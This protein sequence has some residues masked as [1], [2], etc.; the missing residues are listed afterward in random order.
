MS[1]RSSEALLGYAAGGNGLVACLALE[2]VVRRVES[3]GAAVP[4]LVDRLLGIVSQRIGWIGWFTLRALARAAEEPVIHRVLPRLGPEWRDPFLLGALRDFVARRKA[5]GEPLGLA[6]RL[7]NVT[8]EAMENLRHL[9]TGLRDVAPELEEELARWESEHVDT[10]FLASVGRVWPAPEVVEG[11][12]EEAELEAPLPDRIVSHPALVD[13][14]GEILRVLTGESPRPILVVGDAGVGKSVLIRCAAARL[15]S[16]GWVVFEASAADVM[17]GQSFIGQ[18]E[19]RIQKLLRQIGGK[20]VLWIAPG[21]NELAWAGRHSQSTTGVLDM[22]L[23]HLEAGSI[24]LLGELRSQALEKLVQEQPRIR[25]VVETLRLPPMGSPQTL[26]LAR[27]WSEAHGP[28]AEPLLSEETLREAY[29]L[30]SQYL[31]DRAPP[32][33]LLHFLTTIRN[34]LRAS[35]EERTITT[36]DL[37]VTLSR[38]TGLPLGIL[39]ERRGLDLGKLQRFFEARVMGQ[40]EAVEC[41]VERVAMIKAGLTDPT[42]PQGVFLFVG[43][44]GTG[45]TEIAKALADYLFGSPD[46]MI[47]VDMSELQTPDSLDRLVGTGQAGSVTRSLVQE[48]RKEPFSVVLLDEFEKSHANVWDLFLQLFDDGRLTD[49]MGNTADFRHAI[50]ILTSNLGASVAPGT[51]VGFHAETR[52]FSMGAV[53]RSLEATFRPEF[54]NRVDRV[55]IFRPLGRDVMR[56]ILD[57]ELADLQKRR[58]LRNRAWAVE[59]EESAIEFLLEK[60]FTPELG[61]RPLKRA[62]ERYVLSPL[63]VA[64]VEHQVPEGDQF[65]F[66]RSDGEELQVEWVDPDAPDEEELAE[67]DALLEG[68]SRAGGPPGLREIALAARGVSEEVEALSAEY[69]F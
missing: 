33:N 69:A 16:D 43:P 25:G 55:V 40:G 64:M 20:R 34:R 23:P 5:R 31:G 35:G 37:L 48:I 68:A 7:R 1:G 46:R 54:L 30:A 26:A 63:A 42:R 52:V 38:L 61:A 29:Q 22:I 58:G 15:R 51:H 4:A 44:T 18:L 24:H 11:G 2:A 12:S 62:I 8:P 65:L 57:K 9:V 19:D 36:E 50:V 67:A 28:N 14:V 21:F 60:G 59:W 27:A 13:G 41:L 49:R 45:K 32:G 6:G 17:A 10:Q 53:R 47:R 39:D 56:R 3:E 66:V